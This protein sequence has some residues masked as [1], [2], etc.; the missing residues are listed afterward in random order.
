[1]RSWAGYKLGGWAAALAVAFA[2]PPVLAATG[3]EALPQGGAACFAGDPGCRN[4]A[5]TIAAALMAADNVRYVVIAKVVD[6][7][8]LPET[9]GEQRVV[10]ARFEVRR[11]R[12]PPGYC[13]VPV[14]LGSSD[15]ICDE[16]PPM[17][18]YLTVRI[19]SDWFTWPATGTSRRVAR[20]AG[21]HLARLAKL[22]R[23]RAA[24]R[25]GEPAHAERKA[26]LEGLVREA[27]AKDGGRPAGPRAARLLEDRRMRVD[28]GGE[29][30]LAL[31][32]QQHGPDG[33]YHLPETPEGD[34]GE[35][36]FFAGDELEDMDV[37]L[38]GIGNCL[39]VHGDWFLEPPT[40]A[41]CMVVARGMAPDQLGAPDMRRH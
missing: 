9:L 41:D 24:G 18:R 8:G 17:P 32:S 22:E 34:A 19:P 13:P 40:V 33:T 3:V 38:R 20:L 2:W 11:V 4:D 37:G 21:V 7:P 6:A 15:T 12:K 30:L 16:V 1:M 10:A 27:L 31:G 23:E 28:V 26:H 5:F 36:H 29:Y 35:W 39:V 25:I 14:R